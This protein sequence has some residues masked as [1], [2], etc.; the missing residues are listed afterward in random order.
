MNRT[1]NTLTYEAQLFV[2]ALSE[3]STVE[4]GTLDDCRSVR[5]YILA[6]NPLAAIRIVKIEE[7]REVVE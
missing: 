6:G 4:R 5:N 3:W 2:A 1:H 7:S